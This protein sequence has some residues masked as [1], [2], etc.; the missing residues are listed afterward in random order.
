MSLAIDQGGQWK[1]V[2]VSSWNKDDMAI[3]FM[4]LGFWFVSRSIEKLKK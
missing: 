4:I 2:I 3:L 1:E